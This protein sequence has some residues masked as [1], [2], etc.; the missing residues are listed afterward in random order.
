[1]G[2][3]AEVGGDVVGRTY[4][5]KLVRGPF[6]RLP[7]HPSACRT[8]DELFDLVPR[9]E[10][11]LAVDLFCGA[12]GL[13]LGL[14]A[15][16]FD[17]VVGVDHDREALETHRAYHAG[18]SVDW[19]LG[20][21]ETV[22]RTGDL[23]RRLGVTLLAGGPPCQPFSRAGRSMIRDLVRHGR[24]SVYDRRRD[25]W[26]S[27]VDVA[28]MARP[29]A[30]LMEN[31]PDMALDRGMVILR[32]MVERL[33]KLGYAVEE[34]V[35]ETF[36]YGVPQF[37]QRLILVALRDGVQ[38]DWPTEVESPVTVN[39]AIGDLPVVEGGWR[40]SNGTGDDR[41]AS[42]WADYTGPQSAFQRAARVGVPP[43]DTGRVFDHI[44]RPVRTDDA[45]AFAQMDHETRYSHLEPHLKR[46]RDD[47][48]DDKYKRLD[49]NDFSRTITA[50]IAKD[51]YWYIHPTQDR[52]ITVREAARL[53]TFPDSARFAGP[54]SS[55]FRQIGNAVP[56]LLGRAVGEAI[57][58]SLA[59]PKRSRVRTADN[60]DRL[61]TWLEAHPPVAVPWLAA[62]NRWT[63]IAAEMLW[64]RSSPDVAAIG[65]VAIRTMTSP[66]ATVAQLPLI[67][68]VAK[69][70]RRTGRC[71]LLAE[72]AEWLTGHPG[73]LDDLNLTAADLVRIPNV[74]Q[75]VADLAVRVVPGHSEDPVLAGY[76]VL[77]VAARFWG[78]AVDRQNRLS[79]GRLAVA[80]LIG[81]EDTS[82]AAHLAL[83]E[84]AQEICGPN[85]RSCDRC[86][87]DSSCY[88][89][90]SSSAPTPITIP[91]PSQ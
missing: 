18:L 91:T 26:E 77:R 51:G 41:V 87:L 78:E 58:R 32:S 46:Y 21:D 56:P 23:V 69:G 3:R 80:R 50:H 81:G 35:V 57:L 33:E 22:C 61:A 42:G 25:L 13:S 70:H 64:G 38:F 24:R 34:R 27:F 17:V 14:D 84:L 63:V 40:P 10:R 8:E 9:L 66:E 7:P 53:Q 45:E 49:P 62:D 11:P 75:A 12:G 55:A 86:P 16:G 15:A 52:T 2:K 5:V 1:V 85:G 31:V 47:I 6:V 43:A 28:E 74:S 79:D 71:A 29:P 68:L 20:D 60:A 89:A 36:R 48:F 30:V 82:H 37:R 88:T 44:T 73:M 39:A 72:T 59:V 4:G 67:E 83:I 19:D 76:G 65:W 54:P 90:L